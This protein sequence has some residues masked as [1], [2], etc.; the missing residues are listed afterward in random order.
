M[1]SRLVTRRLR[2]EVGATQVRRLEPVVVKGPRLPAPS[3][4]SK[5]KISIFVYYTWDQAAPTDYSP[6]KVVSSPFIRGYNYA[7]WKN[8]LTSRIQAR[9]GDPAQE[10]VESTDGS[11]N[12]VVNFKGRANFDLAAMADIAILGHNPPLAHLQEIR[13]ASMIG[14]KI[15]FGF[16]NAESIQQ[17]PEWNP[18]LETFR[19]VSKAYPLSADS[20]GCDK[21]SG[22]IGQNAYG[23]T[24]LDI[25]ENAFAADLSGGTL[26]TCSAVFIPGR[27]ACIHGAPTHA[28]LPQNADLGTKHTWQIEIGE[29]VYANDLRDTSD[30][31]D[32]NNG[33]KPGGVLAYDGQLWDNVLQYKYKGGAIQPWPAFFTDARYNTGWRTVLSKLRQIYSPTTLP[34]FL[35]GNNASENVN[36]YSATDLRNRFFE[37]FFREPDGS[38]PSN[39]TQIDARLTALKTNGLRG[40]V[41]II[42]GQGQESWATSAGGATPDRGTWAA[43][44]QRVIDLG[45]QDDLWI[46]CARS[47]GGGYIYWQP[48]FRDLN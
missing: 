48:E 24:A 20:G 22:L 28:G 18:I 35:W 1:A 9:G 17:A 8:A 42:K 40:M 29:P 37:F 7:T 13:N 31:F 27:V 38:S 3:S 19:T 23:C 30:L 47:T 33:Y 2:L 39:W 45:L 15:L 26:G 10:I 32:I 34:L 5:L 4:P 46:N 43:L 6:A 12:P 25:Y 11:G 41:G 14:T 36:I 21:G 44:R 16:R